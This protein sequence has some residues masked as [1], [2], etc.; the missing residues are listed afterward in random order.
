MSVFLT[1]TRRELA[2][3]FFSLRGYVIMAGVQLLLGASLLTVVYLLN[4]R[5]YDLP[6]TEKF[7]QTEFFW[8][9][10]LMVSPVITMRTFA[11]EKASG[12]FET[13]M[14]TPVSDGHVILA[15]FFGSYLFFMAAFLPML[16]Y[17]FLLEHYAHETI[18]VDNGAVLSLG[19]GIALFGAFF[20][21]MG[22]FASS[23]TRSQIVAAVLTF[24]AGTSL[25]ILGYLADLRP[26]EINWWH[27]VLQHISILQHMEDFSTGIVDSRPIVYY[28]SLTCVF[29]FLTLK[30]V[31]SHRWK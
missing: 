28:L 11:Q 21:A 8:L 18:A 15:K 17:P 10:L 12:T 19:L 5:A 24:A 30:S 13:L 29:L 22:C 31:G 14:T 20:M 2:S 3:H 9:V 1:L 16:T 7:P 23:L 25:F 6:F 27:P 26:S 4:G